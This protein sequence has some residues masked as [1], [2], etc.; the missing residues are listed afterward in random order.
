MSQN[1]YF[2]GGL[3]QTALLPIVAVLMGLTVLLMFVLPRK[4]AIIPFLLSTFLIPRDQQVVLGGVHFYVLRIIIICA[5]IHL[6]IRRLSTSG[7]LFGG[8][9]DTFDKVFLL[10]A[11]Y[12]SFAFLAVFHFQTGAI[13]NQAGVLLDTLG[14]YF[15]LRY[16]IRGDK[17]VSLALVVFAVIA[18]IAGPCM[19]YE[20]LRNVNLFGYLGGPFLPEMRDG[21]IRA[22]GPFAHSILAGTFG[23]TLVPLLIWLWKS[24]EA[25][26]LSLVGLIGATL[27][28]MTSA[29]ST[30]LMAYGAGILA[31]CFWPLR[32]QMRLFRWGLVIALLSLHVAMKAPVWF[33]IERVSIVG[34]SSG[35]HRAELVDQF[36][37]NF[38]DWWLIGTDAT[39]G[40]G[41]HLWDL[42]NQFVAEGESGGLITFACFIAMI[43]ICFSRIGRSRRAV[44]R[45]LKRQWY[46][47]L[48][49]CALFAHIIA[50]FG[51]SYF[52]HTQI[53]WFALFAMISA[54]TAAAT[55]AKR[56]QDSATQP[57]SLS[58]N[59]SPAEPY[60]VP[61]DGIF[62]SH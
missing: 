1:W 29:S 21:A 5:W 54:S 6:G 51:I 33:L 48:F 28:T 36:I 50:F 23:A 52:D 17:D 20:K 58:S 27:M 14:A 44:S 62:H 24:G 38:G 26:V 32:K 31:I 47:W 37:R 61:A 45:S 53:A 22:Q 3:A 18:A 59:V 15:L 9:F 34:G 19:V 35:Y 25:R 30:P 49:G 60:P 55:S 10:W 16:L 11:V 39:S 46:F 57:V 42:S 7:G 41:D 56:I 4:Y 8:N 2:G 43:S 13:I 12:R 40:Y